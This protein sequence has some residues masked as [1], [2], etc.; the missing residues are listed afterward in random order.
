M[1]PC[2]TSMVS[3]RFYRPCNTSFRFGVGRGFFIEFVSAL[4]VLSFKF[5]QIDRSLKW[6]VRVIDCVILLMVILLVMAFNVFFLSVIRN[7]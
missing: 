2:T 1:G 4:L 6:T 5:V 3:K 7:V